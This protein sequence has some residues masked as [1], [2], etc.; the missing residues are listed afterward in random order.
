MVYISR[1]CREK[2]IGPIFT[3]IGVFQLAHDLITP[4]KFYP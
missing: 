3:K 4:A 1:I 2:P